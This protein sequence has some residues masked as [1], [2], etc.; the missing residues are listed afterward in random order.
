MKPSPVLLGKIL[1]TCLHFASQSLTLRERSR[2]LQVTWSVLLCAVL[3]EV[4]EILCVP[5]ISEEI[6]TF[7]T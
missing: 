6:A 4:V 1:P 3:F 2:V 5:Y 7:P